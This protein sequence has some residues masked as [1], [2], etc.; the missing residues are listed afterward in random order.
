VLAAA[1]S[2]S[3]ARVA[4]QGITTAGIRGSVRAENG[5][6]IDGA[7]VHVVNLATG[8]RSDTRVRDGHFWFQGLETGEPTPSRYGASDLHR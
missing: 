2:W 1:L 7:T 4:A 5:A 3:S 6:D 8:Y